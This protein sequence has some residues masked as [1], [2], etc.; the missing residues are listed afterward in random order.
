MWHKYESIWSDGDER[1]YRTLARFDTDRWSRAALAKLLEEYLIAGHLLDRAT[2]P[3]VLSVHGM[4]A[5]ESLAIR[6]WMGASPIWTQRI[7]QV[8]DFSPNVV[9]EGDVET[10]FKGMQ[11]DIGAPPRYLDFQY[12]V[13]DEWHGSFRLPYCG[14]L[15]DAEPMG[16]SF[17][18]LMCHHVEDP[19]FD[20]TAI[21]TNPRARMRPVHRPPRH[22]AGRTPVCSWEVT[23]DPTIEPVQGDP[24]TELVRASRAAQFP[25]AALERDGSEDSGRAEYR[26]GMI[27]DLDYAV[28]THGTLIAL[29][30]EVALQ[31]HL[32]SLSGSMHLAAQY[33]D[34]FA[35]ELITHQ[36]VGTFNVVMER[37]IRAFSLP[38]NRSGLLAALM[39]HPML[40]PRRYTGAEI[41]VT[42]GD[43][44]LRFVASPA[45][46]ES[47]PTWFD[48]FDVVAH[49][50]GD[51]DDPDAQLTS[52]STAAT[53]VLPSGAGSA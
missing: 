40:R 49:R 47:T 53:F 25:V 14:A 43:V 11:F 21:A 44:S 19:T 8:L 9:G 24:H 32:L 1:G 27:Q 39:I 41:E 30:D 48:A 5:M 36:F 13:V 17:V 7:Q 16:E 23:I 4:Q 12:E 35:L 37:L 51:P 6:E 38:K 20:A 46:E 34:D 15:A 26:G 33:G 42:D 22:P 31:A 29:L 18:E 3:H 50:L 28:F 52:L 10:I 2:M 45:R